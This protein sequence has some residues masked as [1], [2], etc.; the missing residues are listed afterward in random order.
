MA[1]VVLG[2]DLGTSGLKLAALDL[3]GAVTGEVE[4]GYAVE[5]P[6]P[7][8]AET[9]VST[10][11]AALDE[12]LEQLAGVDRQAAEMVKLRYFAGLTTEQA[13]ELLGL[14]ERSGYR[15]WSFARAWLYRRLQAGGGTKA[16]GPDGDF[17]PD[18]WQ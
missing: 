4:V 3:E 5:A 16:P 15:T 7:G 2:A 13:A 18:S 14:S 12:A 17:F 6:R 10:W 9:R 11:V 8:W 1:D